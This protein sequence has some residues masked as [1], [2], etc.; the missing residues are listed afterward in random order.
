MS[1]LESADMRG[2]PQVGQSLDG[3]SFRLYSFFFFFGPC[4]FFEQEHFWVKNFEKGEWPHPL[5]E[6]C[7]YLLEVVSTGSFF[8]FF[9]SRQGFS[10]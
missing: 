2:D 5:T 6:G 9:L 10:V 8:F 7:V 4:S 1:G 3:P